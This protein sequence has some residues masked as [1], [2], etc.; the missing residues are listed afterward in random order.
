MMR[1]LKT[2]IEIAKYVDYR[3]NRSLIKDN[4]IHL[5][6]NLMLHYLLKSMVICLCTIGCMFQIAT[7]IKLFFDY[8]TTVFINVQTMDKLFLPGLTLC[9][10]NRYELA[11][12]NILFQLLKAPCLY[13]RILFILE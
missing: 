11:Q 1:N 10:G 9:N 2:P 13:C 7:I 8:P 4:E 5:T 3:Q 6:A 12:I